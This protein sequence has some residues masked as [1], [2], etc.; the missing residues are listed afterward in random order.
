MI[1][2]TKYTEFW[3]VEKL[4]ECDPSQGFGQMMNVH[5]HTKKNS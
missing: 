2:Q 4:P 3:Q 5:R 1:Y